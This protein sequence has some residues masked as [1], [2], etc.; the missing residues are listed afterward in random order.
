MLRSTMRNGDN[1]VELSAL[2]LAGE[3]ESIAI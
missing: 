3:V 1:I 2:L